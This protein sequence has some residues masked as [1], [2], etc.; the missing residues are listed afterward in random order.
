MRIRVDEALCTGHAQCLVHGPDVYE[1]DDL[2]YNRTEIGE[3]PDALRQQA[4][5]GALACPEQAIAVI[6]Q[7]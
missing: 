6:E 2:G 1:L 3:V 4:R 5:R 7:A